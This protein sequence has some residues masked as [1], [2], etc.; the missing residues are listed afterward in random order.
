G[1]IQRVDSSPSRVS[2]FQPEPLLPRN[3]AAEAQR[4]SSAYVKQTNSKEGPMATVAE[5]LQAGLRHHQAG[6]LAEA[7]RLYRQALQVERRQPDALHLLG[8]LANQAGKPDVAVR[9][10]TQAIALAPA[11]AVF[12]ESL[13]KAHL[14]LGQMEQALACSRAAI[15]LQP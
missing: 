7:E 15:R 5:T 11:Q 2:D 3:V 6:E 4:E 12:H 13:A 8:V 9:F 14:A 10:I 1:S